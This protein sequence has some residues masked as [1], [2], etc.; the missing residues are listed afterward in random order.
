M[1]G[2]GSVSSKSIT[3]TWRIYPAGM[4]A[5]LSALC[6]HSELLCVHLLLLGAE[7]L[8][9]IERGKKKKISGEGGYFC[10]LVLGLDPRFSLFLL[11]FWNVPCS[12]PKMETKKTQSS[13]LKWPS[14]VY[15]VTFSNDPWPGGRVAVCTPPAGRQRDKDSE[16]VKH[17]SGGFSRRSDQYSQYEE[18]GLLLSF[19]YDKTSTE[20]NTLLHD[21][22]DQLATFS[23]LLLYWL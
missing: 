2:G 1:S 4:L 8:E 13:P 6:L 10:W 18:E 20:Q 9:G 19:G 15:F 21:A 14:L 12:L 11:F 7:R 22:L 3:I 17:R 16:A 23:L 5:C